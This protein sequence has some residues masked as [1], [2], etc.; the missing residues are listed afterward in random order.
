[1]CRPGRRDGPVRLQGRRRAGARAA[2][3]PGAAATGG[4]ACAVRTPA[5]DA[6]AAAAARTRPCPA[7]AATDANAAVKSCADTYSRTRTRAALS[8]AAERAEHAELVAQAAF[9]RGAA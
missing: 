9:V 7:T 6:G 4:D 5:G 2:A 3:A 1:R 8:L